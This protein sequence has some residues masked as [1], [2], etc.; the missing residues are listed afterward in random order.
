MR[1]QPRLEDK[2]G[3]LTVVQGVSSLK[4]A[5]RQCHLLLKVGWHFPEVVVL[6]AD[7]AEKVAQAGA[8]VLAVAPQVAAQVP[9]QLLLPAAA[10]GLGGTCLQRLQY[11]LV[12][13]CNRRK[14]FSQQSKHLNFAC[15]LSDNTD[16][17]VC[18]P[19][20]K[21]ILL[22]AGTC[23]VSLVALQLGVTILRRMPCSSP[24]STGGHFMDGHNMRH[25]SSECL[26]TRSRT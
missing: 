21:I 11:C 26:E 2:E 12:Y 10:N 17:D 25:A 24:I 18:F 22:P 8:A 14:P 9:A 4:E 5:N 6:V 19:I 1:L 16:D 15:S 23:C 20:L 7:D 3:A 13:L